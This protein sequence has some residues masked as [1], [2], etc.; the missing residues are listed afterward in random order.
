MEDISNVPII[1]YELG[2]PRVPTTTADE[3]NAVVHDLNASEDCETDSESLE[4]ISNVPIIVY[5]LGDPRVPVID[6]DTM[7]DSNI[8]E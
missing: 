3:N 4:D 8:L 7:G 6:N 2:D 5:E 1:V